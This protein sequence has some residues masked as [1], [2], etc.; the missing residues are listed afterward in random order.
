MGCCFSRPSQ[1][2]LDSLETTHFPRD[3][4]SYPPAIPYNARAAMKEVCRE[5]TAHNRPIPEYVQLY[6]KSPIR[7]R[8][9]R[10]DSSSFDQWVGRSGTHGLQR[11]WD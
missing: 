4:E 10:T 2:Y 11:R 6:A 8:H 3:F 5:K 1:R 9:Q 7:K